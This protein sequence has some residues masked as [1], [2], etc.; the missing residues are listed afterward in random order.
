MLKKSAFYVLLVSVVWVLMLTST[1]FAP[2]GEVIQM[3]LVQVRASK[4]GKEYVDP[5]LG[6]LGPRLK[7]RF[8]HK[9]FKKISSTARS[10]TLGSSVKFTLV[11]GMELSIKLKSKSKK[12]VKITAVVKKDARAILNVNLR[13]IK[14]RYILLVVP[15]ADGDTLILAIKFS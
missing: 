15:L 7:K 5:A 4:T 8:P 14:G 10:G 9:S 6:K 2:S 13:M 11:G 12:A 1:L 3:G